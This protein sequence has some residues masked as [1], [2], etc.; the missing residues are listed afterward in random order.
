MYNV[1]DQNVTRSNFNGEQKR[2][3]NNLI[4]LIFR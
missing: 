2:E 4:L 1:K 3:F